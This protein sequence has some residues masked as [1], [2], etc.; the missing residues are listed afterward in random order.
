VATVPA[1]MRMVNG[2]K[3]Y[4]SVFPHLEPETYIVIVARPLRNKYKQ[5]ITLFP[6]FVGE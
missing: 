6:D 2:Q 4:V 5:T 1:R 3:R